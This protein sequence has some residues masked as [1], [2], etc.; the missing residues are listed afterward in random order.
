MKLSD[1]LVTLMQA[2][3]KGAN[4]ARTTR[5][6]QSLFELLVEE[7]T[8]KCKNERFV[9]DFKTLAD[10]LVQEVAAHDI[11][12]KFPS[13][14]ANIR[15]EESNTFT[16][17]LGESITVQLQEDIESTAQLLCKVLDG[18]QAASKLLAQ[19]AHDS[20][21]IDVPA[22]LQN[23]P[24]EVDENSIGIWIDPIDS[25]AQYIEGHKSV[26]ASGSLY[27][28]GLECVVVLIGAFDLSTGQPLAG[29]LNQPFS[30]HNALNKRWS[31]RLCW[32]L[33][34]P[35]LCMAPPLTSPPAPNTIVMSSSEDKFVQEKLSRDFTV[36]HVAGAGYKILSVID[37][38]AEAYL[39]TRGST[40][41][42]DTCGPQALLMALGGGIVDY[43]K[44]FDAIKKDRNCSEEILKDFQLTYATADNV[45][46]AENVLWA[47]SGGLLA[48][49]DAK[50]AFGI[51]RKLEE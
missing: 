49:R 28:V 20:V 30:K 2:S 9:Q 1:L 35:P 38:Q 26:L 25:T 5:R 44:A 14:V 11:R 40:F 50:V 37:G 24:D 31:G 45:D 46:A 8:G 16:N 3:E 18:N 33:T 34:T 22:S 4:I 21:E 27:A 42:W 17:T 47:N 48:Y 41:K 32:G 29:V 6:E 43:R 39:L 36:Q 19:V 13:L 7:K 15:G 51:L 12:A 10:V 23:I